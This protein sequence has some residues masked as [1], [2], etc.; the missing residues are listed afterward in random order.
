MKAPHCTFQL[1]PGERGVRLPPVGEAEVNKQIN[2]TVNG[3]YEE[4]IQ[5]ITS[6]LRDFTAPVQGDER[7]GTRR[8][9]LAFLQTGREKVQVV[10]REAQRSGHE[11]ADHGSHR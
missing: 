4:V 2:P 3:L 10:A 8:Q 5:P 7:V 6:G 1:K 11:R 9:R